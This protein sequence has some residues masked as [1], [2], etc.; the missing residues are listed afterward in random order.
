MARFEPPNTRLKNKGAKQETLP[1]RHAL[2]T[3]TKGDPLQRSIGN[4]AKASPTGAAAPLNEQTILDMAALAP[5][6]RR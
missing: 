2:N 4:Y 1:N 5:A 6:L 3:L